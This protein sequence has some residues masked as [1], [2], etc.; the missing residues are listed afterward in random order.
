MR[1]RATFRLRGNL[2]RWSCPGTGVSGNLNKWAHRTRARCRA[3]ADAVCGRRSKAKAG[4][5]ALS[6]AGHGVVTDA[7]SRGRFSERAR[8]LASS[9]RR[10][11]AAGRRSLDRA[12]RGSTEIGGEFD[13]GSGSTL[14]ACLMH[15]SRTG[16][17]SGCLRGGRVRNTWMTCPVVG[18][19]LR[20][21]R[22]IPHELADRVGLV[23]KALGRHRR[24]L[25]PISWLVG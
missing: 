1:Q 16:W 25:R 14:A 9:Q 4:G 13:P 5:P 24:G 21:R 6:G 23:R 22:V 10:T 12:T 2:G 11:Q 20:K 19:S 15:A 7:R 18:A 3:G 8:V 17:P